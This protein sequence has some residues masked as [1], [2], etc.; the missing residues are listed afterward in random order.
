MSLGTLNSSGPITCN[1]INSAGII[2]GLTGRFDDIFVSDISCNN[3]K[4][5]GILN[6]EHSTFV[7]VDSRLIDVD[8]LNCRQGLNGNTGSFY[9]LYADDVNCINLKSVGGTVSGAVGT[10]DSMTLGTLNSSGPINS[11]GIISGPRG[12]LNTLLAYDIS[13]NNIKSYGILNGEHSTWVDVDSRL[14][15]VDTLNCQ[16]GLNGNTGSFY[17]LFSDNIQCSQTLNGHKGIFDYLTSRGTV[18]ALNFTA[19][20][21]HRIKGNVRT[22]DS[23]F[24][25]DKLRPVSYINELTNNQDIGLIAHELQEEYPFLVIGEKDGIEK[26]SVNYTGIIGILINEIKSLKKRVSIIEGL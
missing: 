21:D 3:I 17:N 23:S 8:T 4:S 14:I 25:V 26:Q 11:A 9:T 22:L 1:N 6:G 24:S 5:Y 18:T 12:V 15:N 7:S 2:T 16:R 13:C 20:S 10:F 19:T